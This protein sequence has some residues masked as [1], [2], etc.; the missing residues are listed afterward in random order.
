[1]D[2]SALLT[3][4]YDKTTTARCA[5]EGKPYDPDT[6]SM[7]RMA[8]QPGDIA[9]DIG[10]NFGYF[11]TLLS[12]LAGH[13]HAFE[14]A[15]S[16]HFLLRANLE[17]CPN[18]TT[19]P[20]ALSD[21]DGFC[22]LYL[23]KNCSGFHALHKDNVPNPENYI[24]VRTR[25]LDSFDFIPQIVKCDAQGAEP[26]IFRGALKTLKQDRVFIIF[27]F[28]PQG[29]ERTGEDPWEFILSFQ[30]YGLSLGLFAENKLCRVEAGTQIR[31][32]STNSPNLVAF[33][34]Y[35]SL[36]K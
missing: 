11:T 35:D 28:W 9:C 30:N 15:P 2:R 8:V 3:Y 26:K 18:V 21:S 29:I 25:T 34:G 36:L 10:A 20:C 13:V 6:E 32:A 31:I 24:K 23:D 12:E 22:E 7:L 16:N 14:P 27:E 17:D 4:A 5:R 19:Y 1:M 33:R